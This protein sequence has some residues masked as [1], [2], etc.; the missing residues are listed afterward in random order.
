MT[1]K[2][3][4]YIMV[5]VM[6]LV[7]GGGVAAIAVGNVMLKKQSAHLVDLKLQARLLDEQQSAVKKASESIKKYADL[8]SIAKSIVPQDKDQ[9][10]AV[11]ELVQIANDAGISVS[12]ITFQTS[13]L[14]GTVATGTTGTTTQ[15]TPSSNLNLTQAKP[16]DG[17]PGVYA[18]EMDVQLTGDGK[19][20]NKFIKFLEGLENNRRT[21]QVTT[22][23]VTPQTDSTTIT[24]YDYQIAVNM[25]IKPGK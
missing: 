5:A 15:T 24:A 23:H 2:R 9:A 13:T 7:I 3:V 17:L 20:Y 21:A 4:F 19:S 8:E 18:V 16:V 14:G 12:T 1:S 11:R 6:I 22:I 25:Y 10:R